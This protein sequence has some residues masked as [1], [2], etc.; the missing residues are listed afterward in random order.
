MVSDL[1]IN[2]YNIFDE[3]FA[4]VQPFAMVQRKA[5]HNLRNLWKR[6]YTNSYVVT[7]PKIRLMYFHKW[8]CAASFPI[9]TFMYLWAIHIFPGS[10]CLFVCS[11][12]GRPI[13]GNI[14]RSDTWMWNAEPDI[15]I[16]FSPAL[17]LQCSI[18]FTLNVPIVVRVILSKELIKRRVKLFLLQVSIEGDYFL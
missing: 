10:F 9:L 6:L 4:L 11:K 16:G 8:N 13:L 7:A 14:N 17:P 3:I 5:S 12:I 18:L 15:D 1:A 2:P